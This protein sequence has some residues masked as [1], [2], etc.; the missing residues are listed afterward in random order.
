[1]WNISWGTYEVLHC[2][3]L[4]FFAQGWAHS[5]CD[6]CHKICFYTCTSADKNVCHVAEYMYTLWPGIMCIQLTMIALLS[7]YCDYNS[8]Q[9]SLC[10][11]CHCDLWEPLPFPHLKQCTCSLPTLV[12]KY[13]KTSL[14]WAAWD[15]GVSV[16]EK[17]P[18]TEKYVYCV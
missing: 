6:T 17:I 1:M 11:N 5:S 4:C 14:I 2:I 18:L 7:C 3:Y 15:Q 13:S 10:T 12:S 9:L 8:N 16:T